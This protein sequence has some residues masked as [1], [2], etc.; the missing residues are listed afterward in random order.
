MSPIPILTPISEETTNKTQ[1]QCPTPINRSNTTPLPT[2]QREYP[3][4][5]GQVEDEIHFLLE[6]VSIMRP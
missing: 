1:N 3:F 5:Q 4:Y 2:E 6:Y